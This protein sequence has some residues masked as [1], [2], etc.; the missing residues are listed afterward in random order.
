VPN[1]LA[2]LP[3]PPNDVERIA[4]LR[5]YNILDTLPE[6][7]YDDITLLAGELCDTPISLVSLVDNDRQW[8]KAKLGMEQPETPRYLAFC[9][10]AILEPSEVFVVEDAAIDPRFADNILVTRPPSIRFY[11][12]APLVT[13][14]GHALGTLC[15]MDQVPRKLAA[16]QFVALRALARQV[17]AHL[18]LRRSIAELEFKD[19]LMEQSQRDLEQYQ[20]KLRDANALLHTQSFIDALTG[21]YNRR[22]F[23]LHLERA[24]SDAI[25]R[26]VALSLMMLDIDHF[27][28]FNDDFGHTVGDE[29]LRRVAQSVQG[30]LRKNDILA[31][32]GGEE[33]A[34][35]L[36]GVAADAAF[37][38]AERVCA[39]V[40][41]TQGHGRTV[42]ISAGVA[43]LDA[44]YASAEL[45]I[46][47]A[48][49][50]LYEAKA[51]GRDRAFA[52]C[53]PERV[54]PMSNGSSELI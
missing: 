29:V 52:C 21:I 31:R 54:T 13:A 20:L 46:E 44:G 4:A 1:S 2:S 26:K 35:I 36:P 9:A 25:E 32:F 17:V 24:L 16:K 38:M 27:K 22:A 47:A 51:R 10:H 12:G 15:V 11:A 53:L 40:R 50:A 3:L 49:K 37:T 23:G 19:E 28:A 14:A 18:E 7:A 41:E 42:T 43:T 6:Q 30:S 48:D 5:N 8:F 45:L 34:V 39:A 33:F